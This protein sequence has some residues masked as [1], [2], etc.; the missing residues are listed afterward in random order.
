[1]L[2]IRG[3]FTSVLE[4]GV[5]CTFGLTGI[6]SSSLTFLSGCDLGACSV[7]IERAGI[8]FLLNAL[9]GEDFG[10]MMFA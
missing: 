10:L 1:M 3:T 8:C 9:V 2:T 4:L 5:I 6:S 7:L